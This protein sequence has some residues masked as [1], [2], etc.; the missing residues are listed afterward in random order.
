MNSSEPQ[1]TEPTGAESP[2][3]RQK[4]TESAGAVSSETSTPRSTAA[5]KIRAPSMWKINPRSWT[6]SADLP[7]VFRCEGCPVAA[8]VG[9][10][11]GDK[12]GDR[13]VFIF[14]ANR[15]LDVFDFQGAIWLV[16]DRLDIDTAQSG[17]AGGFI[18][19]NVGLFADD[20]LLAAL[21]MGQ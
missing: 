11:N 15:I 16:R 18:E 7:G 17:R 9:I 8:V 14:R 2:L 12:P 19:K 21:A 4:V 10:F 13:L 5:L 1:I 20:D 6:K 3:L